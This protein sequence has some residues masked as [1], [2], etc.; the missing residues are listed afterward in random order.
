MG[1]LRLLDLGTLLAFARG[2][3]RGEV[4]GGEGGAGGDGILA[5]TVVVVVV[6]LVPGLGGIGAS[7]DDFG[8]EA[9]MDAAANPKST[10]WSMMACM[11]K[12][13]GMG[14]GCGGGC[15]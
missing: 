10:L 6:V 5:G 7:D 1:C 9:D 3:E 8:E 11:L 14:I 12:S 13:R 2:L 4:A 15:S